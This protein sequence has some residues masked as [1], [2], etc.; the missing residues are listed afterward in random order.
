MISH[1]CEMVVQ[2][3]ED[4][5]TQAAEK[6]HDFDKKLRASQQQSRDLQGDLEEAKAELCSLSRQQD[7]HLKEIESKHATLQ[8]TLEA[9][10]GELQQRSDALK[11]SEER[12]GQQNSELGRLESEVLNFKAQIGDSENLAMIKKEFSDQ[13]LQTRK[14]EKVNREQDFDLR[15]FRQ[16][17]KAVEIVEEEKRALEIKVSLMD[18]LRRELGEVQFQRQILEEERKLWTSYLQNSEG[19]HDNEFNTPEAVV[20]A[21]VQ[22]RLEKASLVER[23]GSIQPE[24]IEKEGIIKSL[25]AEKSR[26]QGELEKLRAGAGDGRAKSR[27]ERQKALAVKEVEYLR[28]QL[29]IFESEENPGEDTG[30]LDEQMNKR[31][32][33]LE[34]LIGQYRIELQARDEELSR[35]E[36]SITSPTSSALKRAH[37]EEPDERLGLLSRKNRKLQSDL[38]TLQ[39]STSLLQAELTATK[40]QL[41]SLQAASRTRVLSLLSNPTSDFE[42]IKH[43]TNK[44]LREE[45]KALLAQLEALPTR[46]KVVPIS[47]LDAARLEIKELEKVV[48]DKEKMMLRL[49]Q[50]WSLK[51]LEFR[52]AIVSL[53]GWKM[54]PMPNGRF[55]MTSIFYPGLAEDHDEAA[56]ESNSL[57]FDGETGLMKTSGGP[58]STFEAEI[59]PLIRFWVEERGEVPLFLAASQLEFYD[60]TTRA[61]RM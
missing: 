19:Q 59:R 5:Q 44:T 60:K 22:E 55:R 21:L 3:L 11:S 54:E 42:A 6:Q 18:G 32:Q 34:S 56:G 16:V 4:F 45:N 49:K 40:S 24:V 47:T 23:L 20:R 39:Q 9:V 48:A 57:I 13:L 27:L 41:S 30:A 58:G 14:L 17:H 36:E 53:L 38:S 37:E 26:L 8:T 31:T 51:S 33:Q 35:R 29:R 12:L 25:D 50:I 2:E 15:H 1:K 46:T 28:E 7:H 10:R 61:A 43:S 52:E